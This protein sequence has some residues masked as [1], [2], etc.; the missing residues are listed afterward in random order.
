MQQHE[1]KRLHTLR[2]RSTEQMT[3]IEYG[4]FPRHMISEDRTK[5]QAKRS[6]Q[7]G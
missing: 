2:M 1:A 4:P 6:T 5:A 3:G 7:P